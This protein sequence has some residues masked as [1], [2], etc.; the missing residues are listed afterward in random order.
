M[1]SNLRQLCVAA[2]IAAA[3]VGCG[4][5]EGTAA[6]A[7]AGGPGI[8]GHDN[9]PTVRTT[10]EPENPCDWIPLEEVEAVLGRLA[11][12]P[13]RQQ[14]CRYT[15]VMPEAVRA[16]RQQAIDLRQKLREQFKDAPQ[17]DFDDD[18]M[19]NFQSDP[20]TYAV[21]LSVD[22]RGDIASEMGFDAGVRILQSQ[23]P[24]QAGSSAAAANEPAAPEGWDRRL[25]APYGF[26]GRIG[27]IQISVLGQAPDVPRELS[28]ALAERVRDRIPDLPFPATPYQVIRLEPGKDAC[29]LLTRAE[30]EAVLGPLLV[31]PYPVL[32]SFPPLA[33]GNGNGCAY[34]TA[35]HHVFTIVPSWSDG[36]E[37]FRI[38]KGVGALMAT[39]LPE[40]AVVLKGPWDD[41]HVAI[42]GALLFLK[43]DQLLEVHFRTSSTDLRGAVRLAALAV[44]RF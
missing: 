36:R 2:S 14:G 37:D 44:A 1:K 40:D 33:A 3:L 32:S 35:G 24:A 5:R 26:G 16:T 30:A 20:A 7:N 4:E 19:A 29:S 15:L 23:L 41:A 27:H 34:F 43:A 12:P 6:D 9:R 8:A 42:T 10:S 31:D 39:V 21:T 11:G 25:L 22:V 28:R 17:E 18:S 38:N 13:Q